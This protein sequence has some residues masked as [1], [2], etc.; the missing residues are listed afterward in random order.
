MLRAREIEQEDE[1]GKGSPEGL[2]VR[3][4]GTSKVRERPAGRRDLLEIPPS[5]LLLVLDH[6]R[7]SSAS[8]L[9]G[10]EALSRA[11]LEHYGF[12]RLTEGRRKRLTRI[13]DVY[14]QRAKE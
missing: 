2:I 8:D 9:H 6:L 11:L 4:A 3:L 7:S 12:T 10:E 5:E 14:R 1:L 13:L